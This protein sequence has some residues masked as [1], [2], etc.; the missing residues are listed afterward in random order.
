[1]A[2]QKANIESQDSVKPVDPWLHRAKAAWDISDSYYTNNLQ[3][4]MVKNQHLFDSKHPPGSKY[5]TQQYKYRSKIFRPKIRTSGRKTEA[6]A[7]Q[8]FFSTV[9]PVEIKAEN[10]LDPKGVMAAELTNAVL[11]HHLNN[12]MSWFQTCIGGVQDSFKDGVVCSY[13]HWL[14]KVRRYTVDVP[15]LGTDGNQLVDKKGNPIYKQEQREEVLE[16][17][18]NVVL[19]P[20]RQLRMH[21]AAHWINP[22]NTSPFV[23]WIKPTYIYEIKAR[24]R[25]DV[26]AKDRYAKLSDDEIK[27]AKIRDFDAQ[28][29]A[30][31]QGK[32]NPE[33]VETAGYADYDVSIVIHWFMI[34]DDGQRYEFE[35][36]GTYAR[37]TEPRLIKTQ[38]PHGKVPITMGFMILEAHKNVPAG[39]PELGDNLQKEANDVA[40]GRLDNVK[41]VM[42]KRYI[43][44]NGAQVDIRS[45]V[46]NA[47]GSVTMA[48]NTDDVRELDFNDVTSSA[49]QEQDR[50]NNDVD[51][52]LGNFSQSSIQSQRS[53]NETVGGMR[54]LQGGA[55]QL[56]D[57]SLRT[58]SETWMEP[59]LRQIATLVQ[60]FMSDKDVIGSAAA[61]AGMMEKYS[62][63]P[64]QDEEGNE[65]PGA[66]FEP[67]EKMLEGRIRLT[68]NIGVGAS[69]PMFKVEQFIMAVKQFAEIL[70]MGLPGLQVQEIAKELFG[71]IGYKD[72]SRFFKVD[73]AGNVDPR[74]AELQ[75]ELEKLQ[76]QAEGKQIETE[77]KLEAERLTQN[78][79]S[80]RNRKSLENDWNKAELDARTKKQIALINAKARASN[81]RGNTTTKS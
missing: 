30:K 3:E 31:N 8:A 64:S 48:T 79:E 46:Q 63:P 19:F 55:G 15:E 44:K 81:G 2:R 66:D 68:I 37:L 9:D 50:I 36:L 34:G 23:G 28:A 13:N 39:G 70:S 69:N 60:F 1:M 26:P 57:Y 29:D 40:N 45:L 12:T 16:D 52:L 75:Q 6:A 47:A 14:R 62:T 41:L 72:G 53:L 51:E 20:F 11:K 67:D 77:G 27:K 61:Q 65:I 35:T 59:T 73:E 56:T 22:I 5:H 25:E 17:R 71:Y 24:M 38:H 80:S 10:E 54:M 76:K 7:V 78:A 74:M 4:Q 18:P 43:V 33:D 58:F 42:N 21:P 49:Y 32:Q